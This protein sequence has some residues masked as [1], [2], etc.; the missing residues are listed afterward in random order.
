M[1]RLAPALA[2]LLLLAACGDA[3]APSAAAEPLATP[4][5]PR[6]PR[7]R[8]DPPPAP[9]ATTASLQVT[10]G[11]GSTGPF[12]INAL[13]RLHVA[14]TYASSDH[15]PVAA[16]VDVLAPDGNVY[17]RLRGPLDLSAGVGRLARVLE[18]KGTAVETYHLVG[19]WRFRL[20]V[21]E[22][23]PLAEVAVELVE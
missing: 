20:S 10:G 7:V 9:P 19:T 1:L 17:A 14:A 4:A 12:R 11:D 3:D 2:A 6:R 21:G 23:G 16:R 8:P 5:G 18:V 15:T 13:E 22:R